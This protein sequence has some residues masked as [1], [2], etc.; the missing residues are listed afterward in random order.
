LYNTT[1]FAF[2][3]RKKGLCKKYFSVFAESK[4]VESLNDR[5]H[6]MKHKLDAGKE[7]GDTDQ[8]FTYGVRQKIKSLNAKISA[9]FTCNDS[10]V[11]VVRNDDC[12]L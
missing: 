3:N 9:S 5:L 8:I 7:F 11:A 2:V 1:I 4:R 10:V 12:H 6:R